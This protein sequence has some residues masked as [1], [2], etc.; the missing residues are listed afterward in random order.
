MKSLFSASAMK[1]RYSRA[2]TM[3]AAVVITRLRAGRMVSPM[4]TAARPM[5]MVPMPIEMSA[6]P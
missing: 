1:K 2:P 4:I 3:H 5:T 6:P